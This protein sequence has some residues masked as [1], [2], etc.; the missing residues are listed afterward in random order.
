[1]EPGVCEQIFEPFFTTKEGSKGTGLGLSMVYGVLR[2]AGGE[3]V[4]S[5]DATGMYSKNAIA[6]MASH[7]ADPRVGSVSGRTTGPDE[8]VGLR[9]ILIGPTV[10]TMQSVYDV[11]RRGFGVTQPEAPP[12]GIAVPDSP[13]W[14]KDR[15]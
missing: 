6:D 3:I 14:T 8:A 2:R 15:S 10:I 5:S 4:V 13:I 1:M 9:Y 11:S 12:L 7:F